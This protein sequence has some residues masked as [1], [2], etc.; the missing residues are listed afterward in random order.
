[1]QP[2]KEIVKRLILAALMATTIQISIS[3]AYAAVTTPLVWTPMETVEQRTEQVS[4]SAA[5][6]NDT[7][8]KSTDTIPAA[9]DKL[10]GPGQNESESLAAAIEEIQK[11]RRED[12]QRL[13][14]L[15]AQQKE[16]EERKKQQQEQEELLKKQ[17]QE[18]QAELEAQQKAKEEKEIEEKSQLLKVLEEMKSQQVEQQKMHQETLAMILESLKSQQ[19]EQQQ[20]LISTLEALKQPTFAQPVRVIDIP[21]GTPDEEPAVRKTVSQYVEENT[22]DANEAPSREADVTFSYSDAALYRIY[23]KPGILT[24]LQ[25]QPGEEIEYIGG[26]DTTRWVIDRAQSG[27][28]ENR[29]WHIYVKPITTG[30]QT[31]LVINT[32]RHSYQLLVRTTPDTPN[33]IIR[34]IYPQEDKAAFMRQKQQAQKLDNES[35][36]LGMSSPEDL[37][38]GYRIKD[39]DGDTSGWKPTIVFANKKIG[40]TYIKMPDT[41][42]TSEAPVLFLKSGKKLLIVNYRIKNNYYIVDRLFKEAE[43]RVGEA[44]VQI[45]KEND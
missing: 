14:K 7:T 16:I 45:K 24:D 19:S 15:L 43:L 28:G 23:T 9:T 21:S 2:R 29:R 10:Q 40:K 44:V 32:N 22:Q 33:P 20:A 34:W 5:V 12:D 37:D 25:L 3:P 31:N 18:R 13:N 4:A 41:L 1:M 8:Q 35:V 26:G 6:P 30:L 36:D 38:F 27:N 42:R 17:E 11:R 39:K